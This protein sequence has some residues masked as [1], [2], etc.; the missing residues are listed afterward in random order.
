MAPFFAN[1]GQGDSGGPLACLR[2]GGTRTLAIVVSWGVSCARE[3]D[4]LKRSITAQGSPGIFSQVA[5]FM[6]FIAQHMTPGRYKYWE[7]FFLSCLF[8]TIGI[9]IA[10]LLLPPSLPPTAV[11][12]NFQLLRHRQGILSFNLGWQNQ[13]FKQ[14]S[15]PSETLL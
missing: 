8:S 3:W 11:L 15:P 14:I 1:G 9:Q 12:F 6:D 7:V 13:R 4:T 2:A 5:A 10:M